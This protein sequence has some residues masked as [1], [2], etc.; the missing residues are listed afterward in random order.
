MQNERVPPPATLAVERVRQSLS[1][2]N[3]TEFIGDAHTKRAVRKRRACDLL[4]LR[5]NCK[6]GLGEEAHA[7]LKHLNTV[8]FHS[9]A[10]PKVRMSSSVVAESTSRL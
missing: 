1:K 5:S 9:R 3:A 7:W 8:L 6:L 10:L 2:K 4:C